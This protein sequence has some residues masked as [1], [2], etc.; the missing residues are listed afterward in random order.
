MNNSILR[1]LLYADLFDYPLKK[2]EIWQWLIG[3]NKKAREQEGKKEFEIRLKEL[4]KLKRIQSNSDYYF[5]PKRQKIVKLR[6][7]RERWSASKI[8]IA[9]KVV[10]ALRRLPWI[11]L[12]GITGSLAVNNS[13]ENDDI[14]LFFI[15]SDNRLWLTRGLVVLSL[16]LKG[17]YRQSGK[18]QDMICPNMFISKSKMEIQP[19]NLYL[20]H[21]ICQLVPVF[22]R[23]NTYLKFL[24]ANSWVGE[25]LPNALEMLKNADQYADKRRKIGFSVV[26]RKIQRSSAIESL[27]MK[28]QLFYMRN[29]RT[30]EVVNKNVIRFHP[31]DV[32]IDIMKKYQEMLKLL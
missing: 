18:I 21:E 19:K 9:K 7:K 13:D 4:L 25:Y 24:R 28:I 14:D 22:D 2:E 5:L 6:K 26:Q 20:A 11:K 12:I 16:K 17:I 15:T 27:A 1:T 23:D 31:N 30:T 32:R 10:I 3:R 29:H 8:E